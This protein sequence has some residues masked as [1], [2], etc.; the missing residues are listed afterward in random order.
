MIFRL[1]HDD[2]VDENPRDLHVARIQ[3]APVGDALDLDDDQTAGILCRHGNRE[4]FQRHGLALHGD[5]AVQVGRRAPEKRHLHRHGT[6]CQVFLAVEGNDL[7]EIFL[8]HRIDL[9]PVQPRIDKGPD[10]DAGDGPGIAGGDI[11][12]HVR[13]DALRQIVGLDLFSHREL[14]QLRRHAPVSGNHPFQK[15]FMVETVDALV[16]AVADTR[17]V[18]QCQS[19]GLAAFQITPLEGDD[20]LIGGTA[21]HEAIQGDGIAAADQTNGLIRRNDLPAFHLRP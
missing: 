11:A 5:V 13:D 7:D 19:L 21:S 10:A 17:G 1:R 9:A 12:E 4:H 16:F 3:R 15:P 8:G 14:L 2:A 6:V 20:Q 18:Q